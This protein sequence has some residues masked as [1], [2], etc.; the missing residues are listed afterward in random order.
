M[1]SPEGYVSKF[2]NES[3]EKLLKERDKLI[4]EIR[5]IE[6]HREEI[7]NRENTEIIMCPTP[8]VFYQVHLEYLGLLCMLISRKFN[9]EFE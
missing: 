3:Y 7:M 5:H 6:K 1:I 9:E 2:E 4:R 8:D